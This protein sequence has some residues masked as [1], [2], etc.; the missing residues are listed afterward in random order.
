[1][2]DP[3]L[4]SRIDLDHTCCPP[5]QVAWSGNFEVL[6]VDGHVRLEGTSM[7]CGALLRVMVHKLRPMVGNPDCWRP[8]RESQLVQFLAIPC[9]IPGNSLSSYVIVAT[10]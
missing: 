3:D 7:A 5:A 2:F 1:M 8:G 10:S 9:H 6:V 4:W